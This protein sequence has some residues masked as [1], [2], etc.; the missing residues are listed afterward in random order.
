MS[1]LKIAVVPVEDDGVVEAVARGGGRVTGPEEADGIVWT[2]PMNPAGLRHVLESSPARWVQLPFAG[3]EKFVQAGV[4]DERRAWTCTKGAYGYACAEHALALMLAAARR[5]HDHLCAGSWGGRRGG[6][7]ERMLRGESVVIVG[8]GGIGGEL[9]RLLR[10]LQARIVAV[11]RSG[12]PLE[13]AER[14]VTTARLGDVVGEAGFVVLAAALTPETRHILDREILGRMH[15]RTWVV[16]VA[17]GGLIDTDALVEA[18]SQRLIGAAA[19][20]VTDPEPLPDGHPLWRLPNVIITPHVANTWEMALPEL[21]AMV[22]R[23]VRRF[24]A[25]E[26]LEGLVDVELGY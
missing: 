1:D 9:V 19:L 23:N 22:E 12:R 16:N 20:D 4:L 26:P 2:D 8:T 17:R 18:L 7:P 10:P 15:V 14:T 3:I 5:L 24:G 11:N 6:V 13:G 25:G 21:R